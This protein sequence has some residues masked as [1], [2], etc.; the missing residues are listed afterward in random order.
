MAVRLGPSP[1]GGPLHRVSL[2]SDVGTRYRNI[3]TQ[4]LLPAFCHAQSRSTRTR[5]LKMPNSERPGLHRSST[6]PYVGRRP[7]KLLSLWRLAI[8]RNRGVGAPERLVRCWRY[9]SLWTG[10]RG[11]YV[12]FAVLVLTPCQLRSNSNAGWSFLRFGKDFDCQGISDVPFIISW[13]L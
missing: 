7:N 4:E 10:S 8:F 1:F 13:I 6:F 12:A 5:L 2:A 3:L 11:R 9:R